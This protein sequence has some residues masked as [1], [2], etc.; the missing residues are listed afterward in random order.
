MVE[1]VHSMRK[2]KDGRPFLLANEMPERLGQSYRWWGWFSLLI[3][4]STAFAAV[5]LSIPFIQTS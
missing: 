4:M 3:S 5:M 2:P 1:G